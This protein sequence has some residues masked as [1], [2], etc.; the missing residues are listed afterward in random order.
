VFLHSLDPLRPIFS[1]I[2]VGRSL[3]EGVLSETLGL[4]ECIYQQLLD[5]YFHG[6]PIKLTS[7]THQEIPELIDLIGLLLDYRAGLRDSEIWL[8]H[9][10]A[11]GCAGCDHLWQDLGLANRGEL[12]LLM[13]TAFPRLANLNVGDMKWKKFIYR[14]YCERDGIYICPAPSCGICKDFKTCFSPEE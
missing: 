2:L 12:S 5:E 11:H 8:A 6:Q 4:S 7:G 1:S 9:I 13:E 14:H 3:N 10:V